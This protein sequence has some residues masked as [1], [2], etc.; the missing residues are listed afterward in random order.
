MTD[1]RVTI[2][3][4]EINKRVKMITDKEKLLDKKEIEILD[5][6]RRIKYR[7]ENVARRERIIFGKTKE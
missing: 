3:A 7:E 1:P 5:R 2:I 4:D 6:E